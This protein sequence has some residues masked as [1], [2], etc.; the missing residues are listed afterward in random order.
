MNTEWK[1]LNGIVA[2]GEAVAAGMEIE[3]KRLLGGEFEP[4][5]MQDWFSGWQYR[6]RPSQRIYS[7]ADRTE[8]GTPEH[9]DPIGKPKVETFD[10]QLDAERYRWLKAKRETLL[11][12]GLFGNGCINK[13]VADV[14]AVIDHHLGATKQPAKVKSL[15]WR[16]YISGSLIW[17]QEGRIPETRTWKRFP[18]GDIQGEVEA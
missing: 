2:V 4:W 8:L 11:I 10:D 18:A 14:E 9:L 7:P 3:C 17:Y 15:C 1:E 12:T 16:S 13:T 6:A 5:E